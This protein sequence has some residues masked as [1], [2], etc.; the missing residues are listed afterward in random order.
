MDLS[1]FKTHHWLVVGGAIGFLIFGF[2]DWLKV[3]SEFGG[4][5]GAN[6]FD[7]FWTG[8][9]P[10][11]LIIGS[12][13]LTFLIVGGML[14]S[15]AAPWPL[16][17]LAACVLG[18]LL[19]LIRFI[20]NPLDG[21]DAYTD[22]IGRG[23]GMILSTIAGIVAAVGAVMWYTSTGA[24]LADL[25]DMDKVKQSFSQGKRSGGASV[26]PPPPGGY[27]QTPPPPP[28]GGAPP[29]PPPPGR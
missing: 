29:P 8:T 25:K 10:W 23:I 28:G 17:V 15:D 4:G 24:K 18:A 14:K 26:P 12:G 7:F 2:F 22:H 16:I 5:G 20:F 11:I 3:D 9:L 6:V 1:K 21:P 27:G 19:L 13:V